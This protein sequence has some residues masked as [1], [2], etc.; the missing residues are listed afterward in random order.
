[1]LAVTNA[2]ESARW[3]ERALGARQVWSL[4]GVVGLEVEGAPFFRHCWPSP[5]S[6]RSVP[7]TSSS[8]GPT[9]AD[10]EAA[11]VLHDRL[12]IAAL[13]VLAALVV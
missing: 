9:P 5:A 12:E 6:V 13:Q 11:F 1:M 8:P 7:L 2:D 3:Y 4:G 10:P